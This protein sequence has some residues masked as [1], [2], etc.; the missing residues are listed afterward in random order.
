MDFAGNLVSGGEVIGK[1]RLESAL[2]ARVQAIDGLLEAK[3]G[4]GGLQG[5]EQVVGDGG[6]IPEERHCEI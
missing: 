3:I 2:V 4:F 5:F 6:E 1:E